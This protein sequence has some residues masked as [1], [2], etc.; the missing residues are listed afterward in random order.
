MDKK[1]WY[2]FAINL[3]I[4]SINRSI[5]FCNFK[6]IFMQNIIKKMHFSNY[7]AILKI[8]LQCY[9]FCKDNRR[10]QDHYRFFFFHLL[11]LSRKTS[12]RRRKVEKLCIFMILCWLKISDHHVMQN[13]LVINDMEVLIVQKGKNGDFVKKIFSNL[14][15]RGWEIKS[16]E[17][18]KTCSLWA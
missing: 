18:A 6:T 13:R 2:E 8:F 11:F 16:L 3:V 14:L 15:R 10:I 5:L 9:H 4:L 17:T 12:K 7:S 1:I